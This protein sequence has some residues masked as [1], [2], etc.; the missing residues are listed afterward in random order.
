MR[1]KDRLFLALGRV[2]LAGF[3][4]MNN[5]IVVHESTLRKFVRLDLS[6]GV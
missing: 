4:D 2:R 5:L 1:K 6:L 3:R